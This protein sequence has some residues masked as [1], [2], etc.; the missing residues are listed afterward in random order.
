MTVTEL[1]RN[2]REG[3]LGLLPVV[4]RV[5]MPWRPL[6]AYDEWDELAQAV[7]EALVVWPLRWTL[8][9]SEH[10]HFEMPEYNLL[11]P[12][13]TGKSLIEVIPAQPDGSIRVFHA[14][15]TSKAPFDVVEWRD[16]GPTGAPA[17]DVLGTTSLEEARFVLRYA[18]NGFPG[19]RVEEV[20]T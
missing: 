9:E 6:D 16:V 20:A 10:E 1:I 14:L 18:G 7:Y 5:R 12:T 19:R 3:L 4:E 11:I 2:F 13:Y 15:G 8:A 17:S